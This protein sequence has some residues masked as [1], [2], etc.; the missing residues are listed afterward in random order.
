MT[1]QIWLKIAQI[2]KFRKAYQIC[3]HIAPPSKGNSKICIQHLFDLNP[4]TKWSRKIYPSLL[5]L[6]TIVG[7]IWPNWPK[8]TSGRV[9][10]GGH[11]P[12][13]AWHTPQMLLNCR[14]AVICLLESTH[15]SIATPYPRA[16]GPLK[17]CAKFF[18]KN[19]PTL[20]GHSSQTGAKFKNL[21][22]A[23][24]VP[25]VLCKIQ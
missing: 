19:F 11:V 7:Q 9:H 21:Y 24:L 10:S 13:T 12:S 23:N 8:S 18:E 5:H 16:R 1:R 20:G 15:S 2:S 6:A 3:R 22:S 14:L 17:F 4:S 25:F